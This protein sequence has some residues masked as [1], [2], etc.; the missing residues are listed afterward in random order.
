MNCTIAVRAAPD[1]MN[2]TDR[3]EMPAPKQGESANQPSM[4]EL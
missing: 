3:F 1:S 2:P 4:V